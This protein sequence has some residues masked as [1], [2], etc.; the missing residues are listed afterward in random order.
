M[1]DETTSAFLVWDAL[2]V[3]N[4]EAGGGAVVLRLTSDEAKRLARAIRADHETISRAEYY[5]R[6]GLSRPEVGALADAVAEAARGD[7]RQSVPLTT[8]VEEAENPRRPRP[9]Q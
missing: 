1:L 9:R 3:V 6:Y 2:P 5:I 8:G 7:V 4:I